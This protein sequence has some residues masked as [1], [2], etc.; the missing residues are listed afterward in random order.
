MHAFTQ[1]QDKTSEWNIELWTCF[2]DFQKAFDSLEHAAIWKALASQGVSSAYV[3]VLK[4]LYAAQS[5]KVAILSQESRAFML[6]RGVK[7][8]DLL[9]TL[10]SNAALDKR[11]EMCATN[12]KS[13]DMD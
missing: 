8:G 13:T 4:R 10:L 2:L 6:G 12:G 5:G 3:E 9:S 1:I 7:Q 11:S